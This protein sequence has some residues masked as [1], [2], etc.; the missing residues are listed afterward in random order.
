[1]KRAVAAASLI[2]TCLKRFSLSL[3][4][5]LV[6]MLQIPNVAQVLYESAFVA[7]RL[8]Q[9]KLDQVDMFEGVR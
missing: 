1:L 5:L 2:S 4:L 3:L 9:E 6:V 8:S 7:W